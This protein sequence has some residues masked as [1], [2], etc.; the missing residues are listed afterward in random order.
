MLDKNIRLGGTVSQISDFG[1]GF[2]YM[3]KNEKLKRRFLNSRP[4]NTETSLSP[5]IIMVYSVRLQF[6]LAN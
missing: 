5:I 4:S 3:S 1:L 2:N 6:P